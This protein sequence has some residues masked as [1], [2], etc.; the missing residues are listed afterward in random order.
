MIQEKI[1][2]YQRLRKVFAHCPCCN[3]NYRLTDSHLFQDKTPSADWLVKLQRERQKLTL[4]EEK[5]KGKIEKIKNEAKVK[6]RTEANDYVRD[7]YDRVFNPI[8]LDPND[9][10]ILCSPV[11]FIVF[12][13]MHDN[14]VKNLIF[15]D[16]SKNNGPLQDSI[17]NVIENERYEFKTLRIR[18]GN[19]IEIE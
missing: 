18:D 1:D 15:L 6:G 7:N 11:D 10:K 5:L 3:K 13:G 17:R 12:N 14:A 9:C 2:F 8:G 19:D 4:Q 16:H